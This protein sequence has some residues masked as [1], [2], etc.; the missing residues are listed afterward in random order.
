V[1]VHV[2]ASACVFVGVYVYKKYEGGIVCV[3]ESVCGCV[4]ESVYIS[5]CV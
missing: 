4:C 2:C 3:R 1:C 5:L